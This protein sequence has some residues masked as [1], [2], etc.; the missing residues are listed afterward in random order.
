MSSGSYATVFRD[1]AAYLQATNTESS[2][3]SSD[4]D[5]NQ[6]EDNSDDDHAE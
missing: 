3:E 1:A 4:D 5:D 6:N 2:D